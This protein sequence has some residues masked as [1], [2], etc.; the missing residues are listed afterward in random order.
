M[1]K[2]LSLI[3]CFLF[4]ISL[5]A[6]GQKIPII[7][8]DGSW[9]RLDNPN[10]IYAYYDTEETLTIEQILKKPNKFRFEKTTG[11]S[12]TYWA[13]SKPFWFRFHFRN[14]TDLEAN[15]LFHLRL[16]IGEN[17][18]FYAVK[19][20]IVIDKQYISWQTPQQNRLIKHRNYIFPYKSE[21]SETVVCYIKISKKYGSISF[22]LTIWQRDYFEYY[23][24][25]YDYHMWGFVIGVFLFVSFFSVLLFFAFKDR[26]YLHYG[27]YVFFAINFIC[28]TQGYFIRYYV[29]GELG[30]GADKA[31]YLDALLLLLFNCLFLLE[32]LQ[33]KKLKS[34]FFSNGT[35]FMVGMMI[36]LI[37]L[38]YIDHLF[39]QDALFNDDPITISNFYV[40][41][42]W[43]TPVFEYAGIIY[44]IYNNHHRKESV[45]YIFAS[46]PLFIIA[47][48]NGLSSYEVFSG[49][50]MVEIDAFAIAFIIEI[51]ALCLLLA[52]R[53]K[54]IR[55]KEQE[56][57]SE[58]SRQQ[59]LR[60]E[61]VLEAEER[62]RVRIA[63]DLH[64]GVGQMI[65]AARMGLGRFS[66]KNK[67]NEPE[68]NQTLDLLEDSIKEVRE[69]SHNMMPGSLMKFGLPTALKQFVNKINNAEILKVDLQIIGLKERLDERIETML[70]RVIQEVMNN[71]IRHSGATNV[72]IELI[73]HEE[74]LVLLIEDNGK[75]FDT[76]VVENQGIG[77]KNITT[78]VEYLNGNVNFDSRIGKGTS[79]IV[80]VPL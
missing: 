75:G 60:T 8:Y 48:Y 77:L 9:G 19:N 28:A 44:C 73:Q 46:F 47:I 72:N 45:Y 2:K 63:R 39:F 16:S 24:L 41:V 17:V 20:N 66:S 80:E 43:I 21:P 42:F 74:E 70:Y 51:L 27:F 10:I 6:Y 57:L 40:V 52:Y 25:A 78:R 35:W 7:V 37:I 54:V 79:V 49:S 13:K 23:F 61:A 34:S 53:F 30:I 3:L 22:P 11:S 1:P 64:D 18:E 65:A 26:L 4:S 33:W 5:C 67:L 68:I 58:Q 69:V 12:P 59:Q 76:S 50:A 32:Y 31:R 62:E 56:L 36:L 29:N 71:I 38:M 15:I 14:K 55:E